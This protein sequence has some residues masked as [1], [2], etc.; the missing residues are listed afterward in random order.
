MKRIIFS[1][2]VMLVALTSSAQLKILRSLL[3]FIGAQAS[4]LGAWVITWK[5]HVEKKKRTA[6]CAELLKKSPKHLAVSGIF[7]IF[8]AK[9][10]ERRS[11][12]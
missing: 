2:C 3:S 9:N 12:T 10:D 5:L 11:L 8:A 1:I 6:I 7:R 4:K